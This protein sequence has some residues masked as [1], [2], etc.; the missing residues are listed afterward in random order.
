MS[1]QE[2]CFKNALSNF[3]YKRG[4]LFFCLKFGRGG[5]F[6]AEYNLRTAAQSI[7]KQKV[8]DRNTVPL[9][10]WEAN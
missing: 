6:H 9:K 2:L 1:S 3:S 5:Q 4:T 8:I 7:G 10:Q